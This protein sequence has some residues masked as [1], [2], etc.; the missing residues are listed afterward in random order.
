MSVPDLIAKTDP[1]INENN[2]NHPRILRTM[3]AP[4]KSAQWAW[5]ARTYSCIGLVGRHGVEKMAIAEA[6]T[7]RLGNATTI[8][9]TISFPGSFDL[10]D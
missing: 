8:I 5:R 1:D 10:L 6:S 7:G 2:R 4:S 9:P 3:I